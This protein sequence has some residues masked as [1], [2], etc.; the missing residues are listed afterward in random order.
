MFTAED[1]AWGII[2]PAVEKYELH[3]NMIFPV[4]EYIS[5]TESADYD[6]SVEGAKRLEKFINKRITANRPV[7]IPQG[8]E[9]RVY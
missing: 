5:I 1:G 2:D 8:Y 4:Y 7:D 6:F 9:N 3:F